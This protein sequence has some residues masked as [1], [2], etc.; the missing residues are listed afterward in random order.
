MLILLPEMP[1]LAPWEG[2]GETQTVT[3]SGLGSKQ[4]CLAGERVERSISASKQE[5]VRRGSGRSLPESLGS[6]RVGGTPPT[7][8]HSQG[9]HHGFHLK[10]CG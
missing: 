5:V 6:L 2:E 1:S 7:G 3:S 10:G 4:K 8:E 9:Q